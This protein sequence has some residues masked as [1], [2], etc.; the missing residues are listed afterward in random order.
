MPEYHLDTSLSRETVAR[1]DAFTLAYIETAMWTLTDD[2]GYSLD[3]LGLHDI[4]EETI[5]AA[6]R[7]CAA[8]QASNNV[9]LHNLDAAQCGHDFWLTR[10]GHGAGFW[11][12]GYPDDI[13]EAL[14]K[15]AHSFGSVDWYLGD[16]GYVYQM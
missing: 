15:Q 3:Y 6:E 12:R 16:D 7:D 1:L 8:F 5:Q 9:L 14:T 10:N 11:D 4:H 13:G 2:D